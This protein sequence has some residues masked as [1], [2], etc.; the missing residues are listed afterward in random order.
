MD[1]T[2]QPKGRMCGSCKKKHEDCSGLD[3]SA[4]RRHE[5]AGSV[6]VV[7]CTEFKTEHQSND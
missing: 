6:V 2:Y 3:F 7:I 5:Q 1:L 4:M